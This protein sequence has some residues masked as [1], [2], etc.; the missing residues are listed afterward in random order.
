MQLTDCER[1]ER[2]QGVREGECVLHCKAVGAV[3]CWRKRKTRRE[4]ESQGDERLR[5]G[6][7]MA[8]R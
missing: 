5:K 2:K 6:T 1:G 8:E 4:R 7:T 3:N